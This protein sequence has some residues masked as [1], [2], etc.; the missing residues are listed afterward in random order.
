MAEVVI[1]QS[2]DTEKIL[3][4]LPLEL[5]TE[6]QRL[7]VRAGGLLYKRELKKKIPRGNPNH[8]PD[9]KPLHTTMR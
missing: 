3:K 8:K 5:R 2:H 4:Q 6:G 7:S 9:V 1:K